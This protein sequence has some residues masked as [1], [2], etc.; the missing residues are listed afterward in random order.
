VEILSLFLKNTAIGRFLMSAG[1]KLLVALVLAAAVVITFFVIRSK[2][3][4]LNTTI[5]HQASTIDGQKQLLGQKDQQLADLKQTVAELNTQLHNQQVTQENSD[6]AV[7]ALKQIQS[8]NQKR[9]DADTAKLHTYVETVVNSTIIP[10]NQKSDLI[11]ASYLEAMWTGYCSMTD[12]S[13]AYCARYATKPPSD[14]LPV[15]PPPAT[16][17]TS[18]VIP[19][20]PKLPSNLVPSP[21]ADTPPAQA[22]EHTTLQADLVAFASVRLVETDTV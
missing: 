17:S 13:N 16:P 7:A 6:K 18:Q 15:Q 12:A 3:E 1:W 10:E 4:A 22:L 11:A 2:F 14:G 21:R 8:D 19:S 5:T 20:L 9:H